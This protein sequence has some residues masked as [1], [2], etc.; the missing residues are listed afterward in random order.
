MRRICL[1]CG[2]HA[3]GTLCSVCGSKELAPARR[4]R[5]IGVHRQREG[6]SRGVGSPSP[7]LTPS[8]R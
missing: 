7:S 2:A 6:R 4:E 1:R 3:F 5:I 8:S